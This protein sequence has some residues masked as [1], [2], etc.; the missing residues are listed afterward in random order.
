MLDVGAGNGYYA[1]RMLGAGAARVIGVDPTL[2]YVMQF[3]AL[4]HFLPGQPAWILPARLEDLPDTPGAFDTVFSMGV[5]YH[6]RDPIGHL[7]DLRG[8]LAPGGELVLETLVVEGDS[9]TL[10]TPADRY[11]R[12]RNVWM[13]PSTG[14]LETWLQRTGFEQVRLVDVSRT[15]VAEQ[16]STEWMRFE[17]LAQCLDPDDPGR[18]V[19]GYPA[20]LRAVLLAR[21][22]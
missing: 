21:S 13:I 10:L 19:E 20:P 8:R 11:A 14:L 12:M 5:F 7:G 3:L 18:T 6:L 9:R 16:R 2:L 15:T 22:A 1:L 17:S 4:K